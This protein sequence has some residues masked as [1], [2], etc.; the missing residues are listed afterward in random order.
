[1]KITDETK[2]KV[3]NT[4]LS[5]YL[6]LQFEEH[7]KKSKTAKELLDPIL[8]SDDYEVIIKK[9]PTAT[10]KKR[11]TI[12]PDETK[13]TTAV[14]LEDLN[15]FVEST[16]FEL[17]NATNSDQ[18]STLDSNLKMGSIALKAYGEKKS[19]YESQAS[20]NVYK[21]ITEH[22]G[23]TPSAWGNKQ[24]DA[25]KAYDSLDKFKVFFRKE[26]HDNN[27]KAGTQEKLPSAEYYALKGAYIL[28]GT[29]K[30]LDKAFSNIIHKKNTGQK[31]IS[32][33]KLK[34]ASLTVSENSSTNTKNI[35]AAVY[36]WTTIDLLKNYQNT[37]VTWK[38]G[39]SSNWE[40][41]DGMKKV[42]P[43]VSKWGDKF[44]RK[45]DLNYKELT[46]L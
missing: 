37:T 11:V 33:H 21:I 30:A 41:T 18:F 8:K 14:K 39:G 5:D 13:I 43:D 19:D 27:A 44:K 3:E 25:C 46:G 15:E 22:V 6:K 26:P 10:H 1:M 17:T 7:I 38:F 2:K 29:R 31:R 16:I 12:H 9:S 35:K 45:L 34:E 36:Y 28:G 4:T 32:L 20:W 40:F 24:I 23:Y 42:V